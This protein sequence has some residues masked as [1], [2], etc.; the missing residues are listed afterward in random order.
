MM[1]MITLLITLLVFSIIQL[2]KCDN[3]RTTTYHPYDINKIY[4]SI[5]YDNK[6][7]ELYPKYQL[8]NIKKKIISKEFIETYKLWSD[9]IS[10][11]DYIHGETLYGF[12]EAIETIYKHQHPIDCKNAQYLVSGMY[13]SGF[14]SEFHVIGVALATAMNLNRIYIMYPNRKYE[15]GNCNDNNDNSCCCYNLLMQ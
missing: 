11:F 8:N 12:E 2:F 3:S 1:M 13:E 15:S 5:C 6:T 7:N 9:V 4:P 10:S 14:G